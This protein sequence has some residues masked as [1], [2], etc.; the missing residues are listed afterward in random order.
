MTSS[1]YSELFLFVLYPTSPVK[2]IKLKKEEKKLLKAFETDLHL[3]I[4]NSIFCQ[5]I[6]G[7]N[8]RIQLTVVAVN[9]TP[10]QSL[11]PTFS[12]S[13]KFPILLYI[14]SVSDT[15]EYT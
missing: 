14:L 9:T 3:E 6:Y 13:Y 15:G 2:V 11:P 10:M 5:S 7:T 4:Q 1:T 8:E 12:G